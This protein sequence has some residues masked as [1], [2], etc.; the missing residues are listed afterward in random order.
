MAVEVVMPAMEVDQES[1]RLLRWLI[2][3]GSFVKKGEPLM[4]I[5]TDKATVQIDAPGSGILTNVVAGE[6]DDVPIGQVVAL[7]VE[8]PESEHLNP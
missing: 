1:A 5:E 8:A 3:E 7:L 4:E 2:P 6:G